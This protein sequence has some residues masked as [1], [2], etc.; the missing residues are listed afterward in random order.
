MDLLNLP[1]QTYADW[2]KENYL[3]APPKPTPKEP[4]DGFS[5]SDIFKQMLLAGLTYADYNQTHDIFDKNSSR[6][7]G[8]AQYQ[9]RNPML[10]GK[11][12]NDQINGFFAAQAL[13]NMLAARLLKGENRDAFHDAMLYERGS[14]VMENNRI[15]LKSGF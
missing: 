6:G 12:S 15:G 2:Q 14:N 10:G 7:A 13:F 4:E 5:K 1:P 8:D 3:Q 9:E 11:P